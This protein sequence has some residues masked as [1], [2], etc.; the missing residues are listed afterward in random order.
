VDPAAA[1]EG[2]DV[3]AMLQRFVSVT[4]LHHDL[5]HRTALAQL[6]KQTAEIFGDG[7]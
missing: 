4:P 3:W 7:A 5:T 6:Q 1:D 2:T